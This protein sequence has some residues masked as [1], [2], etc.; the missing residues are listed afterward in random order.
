MKNTCYITFY[1]Y[2]GGVGRTI[3]LGNIAWE[4]AVKGK[5]VVIIDFDLEAPGISSLKPF[6]EIV[7]DHNK[8]PDKRGG[9]FELILDYQKEQKIPSIID[10]YS[11][12]PINFPSNGKIYIIP[13]GKEDK[14]Y[15]QKLQAFNWNDFY[16]NQGG[17]DFFHYLRGDIEFQFNNPDFVLIDSRTG[18]TD[19]GG[20]CTLLLPDKVVILTGLNEQNLYGSKGVLDTINEHSKIR[21]KNNYLKPIETIIVASHVPYDQEIDASRERKKKAEKILDQEIDVIFHYVPILSLKEIIFIQEH[22]ED[23][24]QSKALMEVLI[25]SY[26]RLYTLIEQEKSNDISPHVQSNLLDLRKNYITNILT[27]YNN[28]SLSGIYIGATFTSDVYAPGVYHETKLNTVNTINIAAIFTSLLVTVTEKGK[29]NNKEINVNKTL[30]IFEFFARNQKIILLGEAGSGKTTSANFLIWCI[31]GEFIDHEKANLKRLTESVPD[32]D[33]ELYCNKQQ[34]W[35]HMKLLPVK[36]VLKDFAAYL[37]ENS[38]NPNLDYKILWNYIDIN[39]KKLN[40]NGYKNDLENELRKDG[41]I[42]IFDGLDEIPKRETRKN[43][44]EIIESFCIEFPR[45]KILVTSRKYAYQRQEWRLSG[46]KEAI[47]ENFNKAQIKLFTKKW[48]E[49][50]SYLQEIKDK[51]EKIKSLQYAIS[52]NPNL[53]ELAQNP[54]LL[55]LMS[56]LHTWNEGILYAKREELYSNSVDLLINWWE[57][58]KILLDNY[59]KKELIQPSV[60]E[61]LKINYKE[62][63]SLLEKLAF[64]THNK[65]AKSGLNN[66]SEEELLTH[67]IINHKDPDIKPRRLIEY[68]CERAGIIVQKDEELYSFSH[69]IFQQYLSACYLAKNEFPEKIVSLVEDNPE[70]WREVTLL[71]AAHANSVS[72]SSLWELINELCENNP[73][74]NNQTKSN[75]WKSHIASQAIV[76]SIDINNIS[77]KKQAIINRIKKWLEIII[78]SDNFVPSERTLAGVNLSILD[79]QRQKVQKINKMIFCFVTEGCFWMGEGNF[80]IGVGNFIMDEVDDMY[81]NNTIQE[82]FCIG[83]YPVT[84][85]QYNVFVEANGYNKE[86]YWTEAKKHGTWI[87]RKIIDIYQQVRSAPKNYRYP[88]NLSNHPVVGITWYEAMAFTRW[89]TEKCHNENILSPQCYITLPTEEQWVKASRGGIKI[90]DSPNLSTIEDN[91]FDDYK[92]KFNLK[93]NENPYRKYPWGDSFEK[94]NANSKENMIGTT[95]SVGCFKNG[96]SVYGC[97]EMSGNVWEWTRS[98]KNDNTSTH[99][100]KY[101]RP[102][103]INDNTTFILKGGSFDMNLDYQSCFS[104]HNFKPSYPGTKYGFRCVICTKKN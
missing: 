30:P 73:D 2:K 32:E 96:A 74:E 22:Y 20:I 68:I 82:P 37:I 29:V 43:I 58:P 12:S 35:M 8:N 83:K 57:K 70:Y 27:Q 81:I 33:G 6:K 91:L 95:N 11:T 76:E 64:N 54:L 86:K 67:L 3:S 44:K 47:I 72:S 36:I 103:Q 50:I 4:A 104:Q 61:W 85:A 49:H 55:T 79:D 19:I 40:L 18:L 80:W 99:N 17:I 46:F 69:L 1:S 101:E 14:N 90:P 45:C 26:K 84:N 59:G 38:D 78:R 94:N 53:Y 65:K 51:E 39:L 10:Y 7:K 52:S 24:D 25:S 92:R 41:G 60:I 98:I 62:F 97:E 23:K 77:P 56:S 28:I 75:M 63:K 31:A 13:A 5:K 42:I 21:E 71:S 9:I 102:E 48:Y 87:D 93:N 88:F 89:L 16:E 66:I 15:K 100:L 34:D